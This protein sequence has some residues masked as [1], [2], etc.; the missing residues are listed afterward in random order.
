[1]CERTDGFIQY[2][3]TVVEDFL[4][5]GGGLRAPRRRSMPARRMT[6]GKR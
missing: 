6:S 2:D 5:L 4:E 3:A 1:M